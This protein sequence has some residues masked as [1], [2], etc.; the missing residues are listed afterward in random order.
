MG[1]VIMVCQSCVDDTWSFH[2]ASGALRRLRAATVPARASAQHAL[3]LP[4][5]TSA[6]PVAQRMT[7]ADRE[8]L[9]KKFRQDYPGVQLHSAVLPYGIWQS[10]LPKPLAFVR[11]KEYWRDVFGQ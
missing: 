9:I 3:Q 1:L 2:P 6:M 11:K 5:L 4:F 10:L 8:A 7:E